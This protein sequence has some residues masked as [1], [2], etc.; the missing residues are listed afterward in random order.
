[1]TDPSADEVYQRPH[2]RRAVLAFM[3]QLGNGTHKALNTSNNSNCRYNKEKNLWEPA[4]VERLYDEAN[5]ARERF[6]S[7]VEQYD[8][9]AEPKYRTNV[10]IRS[11]HGWEDVM[12]AVDAGVEAYQTQ[13][14]T[15]FW[16][17]I[18]RG[19]RKF[20]NAGSSCCAFLDLIPDSVFSSTIC[21]TLKLILSAAQRIGEVRQEVMDALES[22][23]EILS[24][25]EETLSIYYTS[26]QMHRKTASLYVS[27]VD[28]LEAILAW[29]KRRAAGKAFRALFQ[30]GDY[31]QTLIDSMEAMKF[32]VANFNETA[33]RCAMHV[34]R[35][36]DQGVARSRQE[37]NAGFNKSK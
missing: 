7:V 16:G 22:L 2:V 14:L 18:R 20:S 13:A 33:M 37:N 30:Q 4:E 6:L 28:A 15:G 19:F 12:K 36:V 5:K 24:N 29:F 27:I 25:T 31:K 8:Q 1:M 11:E 21:G 35:N 32:G 17:R 9:T 26:D 10:D 34:L 3:S 23:P